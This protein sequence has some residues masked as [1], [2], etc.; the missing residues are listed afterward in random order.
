MGRLSKLEVGKLYRINPDAPGE[1]YPGGGTS[2]SEKRLSPCLSVYLSGT[3][4]ANSSN[5]KFIGQEGEI[6]LYLGKEDDHVSH[7]HQF[8]MGDVVYDLAV[9]QNKYL[10]SLLIEAQ[11]EREE[12]EK[13]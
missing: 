12:E 2:L 11:E 6:L 13:C 5:H 10:L 8:L 3:N 1:A 7:H 9:W 4:K